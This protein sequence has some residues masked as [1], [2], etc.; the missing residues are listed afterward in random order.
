[1]FAA[2]VSLVETVF[3]YFLLKV[4]KKKDEKIKYVDEYDKDNKTYSLMSLYIVK[5]IQV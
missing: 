3:G 4:A 1:M 2:G 5:V